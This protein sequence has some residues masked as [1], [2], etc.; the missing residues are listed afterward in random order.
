[1]RVEWER[2]IFALHSR[3][4]CEG[5]STGM[6]RSPKTPCKNPV[7]KTPVMVIVKTLVVVFGGCSSSDDSGWE[8]YG[9]SRT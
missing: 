1:M 4:K 5:H 8:L 2:L 7:V 6:K 3:E 9:S